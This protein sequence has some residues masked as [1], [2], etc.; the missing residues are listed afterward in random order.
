MTQICHVCSYSQNK[1]AFIISELLQFVASTF[2]DII[3]RDFLPGAQAHNLLYRPVCYHF[4]VTSLSE[5]T[6]TS[7]SLHPGSAVRI[8]FLV[9]PGSA[10][11]RITW[12]SQQLHLLQLKTKQQNQISLQQ[13]LLSNKSSNPLCTSETAPMEHQLILLGL[14]LSP[15]M[16]HLYL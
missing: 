5:Q 3:Y 10:R 7:T 4:V 13:Q 11:V 2:K 15:I 6:L 8:L 14:V 1:S 9:P 12:I 16:L